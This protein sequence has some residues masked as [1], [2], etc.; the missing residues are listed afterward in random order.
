MTPRWR[1]ALPWAVWLGATAALTAAMGAARAHL[2]EA[3]VALAYLLLVLAGS[4]R[5]TRARGVALA[6]LSFLAFNFFFLPPY[7]TLVV[8]DPRDWLVLVTFLVVATVATHLIHR[9][10]TEAEEARRRAEEVNRLSALGA[11]TLNAGRAEDALH[12]VAAVIRSTL[13][14]DG[15]DIYLPG[16][17]GD[18]PQAA[19]IAA[20]R[21][22]GV[23]ERMD[24]TLRLLPDA[25]PRIPHVPEAAALSLPLRVRERTAGVLR[26][27]RAEGLALD[28]GEQR[29]F[30]ALSYYAALGAERVRLA[31]EAEHAQA[32]REA[33]RL[34]DAVVASVSH[35]LRT[36]LTTIKA[37]AHDI[38]AE[39]DARAADIEEEA[40]RLNRFVADLL[41]LSRLN[42]GALELRPEITAAE[43]LVGAALQRV[44]GSVNGREIVASVAPGD[45]I[46]LGRFDFVHA[47]RVLVNLLENAHKYS[48]PAAPVEL[49]AER[50]GDRLLFRVADRGPGIAAED[51][52]R[53]FQPFYRPGDR[54]PDVGGAGLGLSIARGLAEAQGGTL[55]Y[56]P[57]PGGGSIFIFS[58]PAVDLPA[59][60]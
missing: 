34:K 8:R 24:G 46:L 53:A 9:A 45:P 47:L 5:G 4:V 38:A 16:A 19:G 48:P 2:D 57:R 56:A 20:E 29:F 39:G 42:A 35:D 7:Y 27:V 6:F 15:C 44:A 3:H 59:N 60:G 43:D 40:D 37:L 21:G 30:T 13:R 12:A 1:D 41:D 32:L 23:V 54:Q 14:L 58:L 26:I 33:D 18:A 11:E 25:A 52:E 36:P 17:M 22:V 49:T 10:R 31:A 55:D 28:A 51:V 50:D